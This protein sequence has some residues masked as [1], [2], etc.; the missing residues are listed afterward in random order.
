M[1]D[2]TASL[3]V[4]FNPVGRVDRALGSVPYSIPIHEQLRFLFGAGALSIQQVFDDSR[5]MAPNDVEV[6][7][8][9][10]GGLTNYQGE[11]INFTKVKGIYIKNYSL[12]DT[13]TV[14]PA[15]AAGWPGL[16]AGMKLVPD[17]FDIRGTRSA[18]GWAVVPGADVLQISNG[19]TGPT[20]FDIVIIGN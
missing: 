10:A 16:G 7:D 1:D 9:N 11:V 8:L 18:G 12:I 17:S 15:A 2:L 19:P 13:I 4:N 14:A 20:R 6:F 5:T 3:D